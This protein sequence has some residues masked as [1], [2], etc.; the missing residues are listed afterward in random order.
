MLAQDAFPSRLEVA[1][2]GVRDCLESFSGQQVGL[3][4]YG[5]SSSISC[6]LTN[7]Y[8]FVRYMLNQVEPR[9]VEFGGTLLLSAVEKSID[10]VLDSD[11]AGYHDLVVL[12]DG[13]DHGPG[14]E[15]LAERIKESGVS[16]LLVGIGDS[17]SGSRIPISNDEGTMIPLKHEGA[18]VYT[19]LQDEDL[20]RLARLSPGGSYVKAGTS[21]FHLGDI[22][23]DFAEG[24]ESLRSEGGTGYVVY[25]EG[26][27]WILPLAFALT[28]LRKGRS[29]WQGGS[30]ALIGFLT[31]VMSAPKT[32]AQEGLD[33]VD[34]EQASEWLKAERFADA[35]TAFNEV[36]LRMEASGDSR[37]RLAV[38]TFN[39]GLSYHSLAKATLEASPREALSAAVYAQDLFFKSA[40]LWPENRRSGMR[41]NSVA[42]LIEEIEA[43]IE[44]EEKR[45]QER[46]EAIEELL[47]RIRALLEAQTE[48]KDRVAE[49][50]IDRRPVNRRAPRPA[51]EPERT[52]L[53]AE[54]T[55]AAFEDGQN[56]LRLEGMSIRE[57]MSEMDDEYTLLGAAGSE[58]RTLESILNRPMELMG[59]A[60]EAQREAEELLPQWGHWPAARSRQS[61]AI[62][63][64]QEILDLFASSSDEEGEGEWDE[65]DWEEYMDSDEGESMSS[66][67]PVKGDFRQDSLMQPLPVPSFSA[68]D[69]LMEEMGNQQFRQQQRAKAQAGKVEKDW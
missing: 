42:F 66:S 6:P 47:N 30:T 41:L 14:I 31:I 38:V 4:I 36:A 3:V 32:E 34:F 40:R 67:L 39:E 37:E 22:Y 56:I 25:K 51:N 20:A 54:A 21:P 24:K 61:V 48:L 52:P 16:P 8:D 17:V 5:G 18:I 33:S 50:D 7:D 13:E 28:L 65:E 53:N 60:I 64:L 59:E 15:K 55:G 23:R 19:K 58:G 9:S 11:R 26:A 10:Q 1:K 63:R 12:T 29:S 57:R 45:A 69:V 2:Q 62:D 44:T 46:D 49:A 43:R 68:E 35:G 27:F